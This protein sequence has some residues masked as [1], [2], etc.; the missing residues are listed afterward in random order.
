MRRL[1]TMIALAVLVV[2]PR[3]AA[4][5]ATP[6]G[7]VPG[8][9]E[10]RVAPDP[11]ASLAGTPEADLGQG[12]RAVID[13]TPVPAGDLPP[14]EPADEAT[15]EGIAATL[16]EVLACVYAGDRAR[17][18]SLFSDEF[19]PTGL[20]TLGLYDVY[21]FPDETG[22]PAP[23]PADQRVPLPPVRDVRV[24][25]DGRAGA[26]VADPEGAT[27]GPPAAFIVFVEQD[28]RWLIDEVVGVDPDAAPP[29]GTPAAATRRVDGD[30]FAGV[31]VPEVLADRF[32][33]AFDGVP[34]DG[35]WT[36]AEADV[37]AMEAALVP[38][39]R[40]VPEDAVGR[41][42]PDLWE[43]LPG[44]TRQYV[45]IVEEGRRLVFANVFCDAFGTDWAVEPIVVLDGGDCFFQVRYDVETGAFSGLIVNGEA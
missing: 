23:A 8:P 13:A 15:I 34:A 5:E 44:Y 19:S 32:F 33:V 11:A 28:N 29:T 14:G 6:V 18:L 26:I 38:Y 27:I 39:L 10:C 35:Y 9:E 7:D 43:R 16:R 42:A 17:L 22:T 21:A 12:L 41:V 4:Q 30:G 36:P 24:L 31:I 3:I 40:D 1:V 37:R 20:Y 2:A 45:G 25:D